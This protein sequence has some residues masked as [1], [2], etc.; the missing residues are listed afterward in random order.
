[1]FI[2]NYSLFIPSRLRSQRFHRWSPK[3]HNYNK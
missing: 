1:M 2:I 3:K